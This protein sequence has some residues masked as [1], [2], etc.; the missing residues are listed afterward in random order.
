MIN[1]DDAHDILSLPCASPWPDA[2]AIA[3]ATAGTATFKRLPDYPA[4]AQNIGKSVLPFLS[5]F[6]PPQC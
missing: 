1:A 2:T 4:I 6:A 3:A 5:L